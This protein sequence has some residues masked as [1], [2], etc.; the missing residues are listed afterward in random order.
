M[1][2]TAAVILPGR[3]E[4]FGLEEV[5][6]IRF[7]KPKSNLIRNKRAF[8]MHILWVAPNGG[9]PEFDGQPYRLVFA[10]CRQF[11]SCVGRLGWP[12]SWKEN[13]TWSCACLFR[14]EA[15]QPDRESGGFGGS[16]D[17]A[18]F[19]DPEFLRRLRS[20]DP[21][22]LS[23]VVRCLRA[24]MGKSGGRQ[25]GLGHSEE[26]ARGSE[27][28]AGLRQ[29]SSATRPQRSTAILVSTCPGRGMNY[30]RN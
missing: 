11:D 26:E 27:K 16:V 7:E 15:G 3:E 29:H 23:A 12:G 14:F 28:G 30:K 8:R 13:R 20:R 21:H 5:A 10:I 4:G 1:R 25:L 2:H 22:A 17:T 6:G 19:S 18:N 24:W 9:L